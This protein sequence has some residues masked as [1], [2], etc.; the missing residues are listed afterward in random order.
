MV[1]PKSGSGLAEGVKTHL[2]DKFVTETYG[3][4]TDIFNKYV[5]KGLMVEEDSITLYTLHTKLMYI[6]N[7]ERISNEYII[8][9]PDLYKGKSI[10]EA[11]EILDIKSS[12]DIFTFYRAKYKNYSDKTQGVNPAYYWQLQGYMALTGA[13]V[14]KL[15][16]CL[17]DT[18]ESIISD[19]KYR[20]Y[21]KMGII[22]E[23]TEFK[24][25]CDKIEKLS[26]YDDIP[27][28]ERIFE[29]VVY[30]NDNDIDRLYERIKQCNNYLSTFKK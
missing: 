24:E 20:L 15:V 13:N 3:R 8:G 30:R 2:I 25:A 14:S 10:T 21:R 1:E 29:N 17:T 26:R 27:L 12:W 19:E 9:T 18:P 23:T 5:S 7:E 4:E 22:D 28:H 11:T 16:Y 6:K